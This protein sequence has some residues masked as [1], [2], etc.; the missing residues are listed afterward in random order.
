MLE[1]IKY[2]IFAFFCIAILVGVAV[3][4]SYRPP[5][6]VI[7]IIPPQP[8]STPGPMRVYV[9]GAVVKTNQIV[10]VLH[11]SRVIDVIQAAGGFNAD[12]DQTKINLARAVQDGEQINV[13]QRIQAAAGQ[14][15]VSGTPSSSA[16]TSPTAQPADKSGKATTANPVYINTADETELQRLP[17]VGPKLA[18][19]IITYRNNNGPFNSMADVDKVPGV[20][21]AKLKDWEGL[22]IF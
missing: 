12:A 13:P 20:G 21:P 10:E 16:T 18:E 9:T 8:T 15:P 11:G 22:I 14:T 1:R 4:L 6:T 2:P 7:T 19:D 3:L 5:A 17:G